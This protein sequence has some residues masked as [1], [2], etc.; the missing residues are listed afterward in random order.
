VA[1][2][3]NCYLRKSLLYFNEVQLRVT[4]RGLETT[5]SAYNKQA[6]NIGV[7]PVFSGIRRI[8]EGIDL[9]GKRLS[10]PVGSRCIFLYW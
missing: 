7:F 3:N 8:Y 1:K 9:Y 5:P 10:K 6:L 4:L 2:E